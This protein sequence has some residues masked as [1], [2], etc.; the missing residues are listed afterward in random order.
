VVDELFSHMRVRHI[1]IA[2][3]GRGD[4]ETDMESLCTNALKNREE[5]MFAK[6]LELL[7]L[8]EL[9]NSHKAVLEHADSAFVELEENIQLLDLPTDQKN[10]YGSLLD[11]S[12]DI[13]PFSL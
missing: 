4:L 5:F 9:L 11:Y 8:V 7:S 12:T 6:E 1:A 2:Q 13:T 3:L 10:Q